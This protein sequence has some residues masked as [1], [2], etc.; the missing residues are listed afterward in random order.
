MNHL[1]LCVCSVALLCVSASSHAVEV[2]ELNGQWVNPN[3]GSTTA[4]KSGLMK[5][6]DGENGPVVREQEL[7]NGVFMGVV[8]YFKDGALEREYSVNEKRQS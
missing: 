1:T 5:C 4:G 2:C 3:N 6:R 7:Q 8:R